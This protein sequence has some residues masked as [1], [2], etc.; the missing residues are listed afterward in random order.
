MR[1]ARYGWIAPSCFSVSAASADRRAAE[2][3][4]RIPSQSP[5][6]EGTGLSPR[7]SFS[8]PSV[9]IGA[10]LDAEFDILQTAELTA[11]GVDLEDPR[12]L[13]EQ[14]ARAESGRHS[15]A[16]PE[17][18][19]QVRPLVLR[20]GGQGLDETDVLLGADDRPQ[21]LPV[22]QEGHPPW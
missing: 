18:K 11:V 13:R 22:G 10:A 1:T 8:R 6:P 19:D 4:R 3:S 14:L 5:R 15:E 17:Q 2:T 12:A 9:P 7:R 16:Q 20:D 21:A